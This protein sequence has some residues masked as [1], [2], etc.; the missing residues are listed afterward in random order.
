MKNRGL[1]ELSDDTRDG[2]DNLITTTVNEL[3]KKQFI[4]C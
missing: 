3:F 4:S 2:K 1:E